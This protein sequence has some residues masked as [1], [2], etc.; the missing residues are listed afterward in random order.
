LTGDR[1]RRIAVKGEEWKTE[2]ER[3]MSKLYYL[4]KKSKALVL[5]PS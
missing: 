2:R 4:N 3:G 1:V 5:M